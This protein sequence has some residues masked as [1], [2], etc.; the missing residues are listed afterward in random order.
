MNEKKKAK[1]WF[2]VSFVLFLTAV[3]VLI[4]FSAKVKK[5]ETT[6]ERLAYL[7]HKGNVVSK[8]EKQVTVAK[9]P[10]DFPMLQ[11][12]NEDIYAWIQIPGTFVDYPILQHPRDNT[13]YLKRTAFR[14][15]APAGSIYTEWQNARDFSDKNTVLYGHNMADGTMFG[16]LKK[17][18]DPEFMKENQEVL[19]YTRDRI[20]KYRIFA[21]V[22]YDNRHLLKSFR[23]QD[24]AEYQAF[25]D[26]L[27]EVRNMSSYRDESVEVTTEDR[28]ITL[29]TCMGDDSRRFLVEAVLVD[30]WQA[31]S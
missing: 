9:N 25:L 31:D 14:E 3:F 23:F 11:E 26:S 8:G 27:N 29:S 30:E 6:Y 22:T 19:I 15:E 7:A 16:G 5:E 18:Q 13:Y 1:L 17:F 20:F 24:P 12:K 4:G 10:I 2:G 28:I 21:A